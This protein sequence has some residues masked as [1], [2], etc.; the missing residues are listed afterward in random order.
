VEKSIFSRKHEVLLRLL[1]QARYEANL[2]QVE[3][4]ER[5]HTKQAIISNIE[6]GERRLDL[7]EL[8]KLCDAVGVSVAEFARRFEQETDDDSVTQL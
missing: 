1:R 2:T 8:Q 6:R 5:L 4:A 7:I 3:L